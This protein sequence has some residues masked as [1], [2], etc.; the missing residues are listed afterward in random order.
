MASRKVW[1]DDAA[2]RE[3]EERSDYLDSALSA[4]GVPGLVLRV[5]RATK[6]W[7]FRA[8]VRG[9][10][11]VRSRLGSYPNVTLDAARLAA[12][13]LRDQARD[14]TNFAAL[15]AAERAEREAGAMTFT[16]LRDKYLAHNEERVK[17]GEM[18][19]ATAKSYR[20][21]LGSDYVAP[22]ERRLIGTI[23]RGEI[24]ALY[25]RISGLGHR[26]TAGTV[27]R[28]IRSML[29]YATE[30]DWLTSNP[31]T[32]LKL[33]STA[34]DAAPMLRWREGK[35]LDWSELVATLDAIDTLENQRPYSPW[36]SIY[37]L[38]CLTG[39]RPSVIEGLDWRELDLG[40]RPL[41]RLPAERSKLRNASDIPLSDATAELLR[42]LG[43]K[44]SGLVFY[45]R[46]ADKH[47][48][49]PTIEPLILKQ[50]LAADAARNG[51]PVFK[52]SRFRDTFAQWAE[53]TGQDPRAVDLLVGHQVQRTTRQKH[54]AAF[55]PIE[56][57]REITNE[58]ARAI[59]AARR[60][61]KR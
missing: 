27:A 43:P 28:S 54:Y 5:T 18:R 55:S 22:F 3:G 1:C 47:L 7:A 17:A 20:W 24:R 2:L 53:I 12:Q 30:H 35:P 11:Q 29:S 51:W 40:P 38:C 15:R 59:G 10:R 49:K 41:L 45:G 14:G 46:G 34:T 13:R 25:T 57:A 42:A 37:R 60:K 36:I 21:A 4:E 31:A 32:K 39:A 58:W 8:R 44:D 33:E 9:G 61:A 56:K 52:Q 19:A 50:L 16:L 48:V 6:T 26:T 23:K